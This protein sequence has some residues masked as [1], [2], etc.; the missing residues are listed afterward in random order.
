MKVLPPRRGGG[1][2]PFWRAESRPGDA[3][4]RRRPH[5]GEAMPESVRSI[6]ATAS[7]NHDGPEDDDFALV[8]LRLF[9]LTDGGEQV[10]DPQ[11]A[12]L[13]VRCARDK[14][15]ALELSVLMSMRLQPA[16][17]RRA[18]GGLAARLRGARRARDRDRPGDAAR[19]EVLAHARPRAARRAAGGL[20]ARPLS[21]SARRGVSR[22]APTAP[23][24]SPSAATSDRRRAVAEEQVRL[25]RLRDAVGV[26]LA[27][28]HAEAAAE[29]D[30]L[31][32][33]DVVDRRDARAEHRDRAV[34]ELRRERVARARARPPRCRSSAA[35]GRA[36]G[37]S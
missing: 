16:A 5:Y 8:D 28:A 9:A 33:E 30:D 2:L 19:A 35:R 26:G 18:P 34:D 3:T 11:P 32:V 14:L 15:A 1:T 37:R 25:H 7:L 22:L 12:S 4:S 24:R 21:A 27:E 20:A 13:S 29:D 10:D 17:D 31:D 23:P 36:C 6:G